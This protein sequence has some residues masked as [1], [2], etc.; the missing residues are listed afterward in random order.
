MSDIREFLNRTIDL[1][2]IMPNVV[3]MFKGISLTVNRFG[4]PQPAVWLSCDHITVRTLD[5]DNKI[6]EEK[7]V[8]DLIDCAFSTAEE[9]DDFYIE[10]IR[11]WKNISGPKT[12]MPGLEISKNGLDYKLH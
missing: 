6:K 5:S 7:R 10:M 9:R 4:E 8:R 1:D 11:K 2:K 3:V 12:D